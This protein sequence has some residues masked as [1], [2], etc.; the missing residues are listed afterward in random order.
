MT[1]KLKLRTLLQQ[2]AR[3]QRMERGTICRMRAGAYYNHQTWEQGRNVVRYV[4]RERVKDLKEAI[5]GYQRYLKL[6][7]AYA[8]E[9]IRRT[10]QSPTG[11]ASPHKGPK[12][13][14]KPQPHHN[15]EF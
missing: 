2:M 7:Q 9:I 13:R 8:E 3:I 5:A 12:G 11:K 10:R 4:A 14:R 1:A 15:Q 6:T